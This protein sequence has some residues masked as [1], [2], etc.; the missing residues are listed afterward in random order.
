L[1]EILEEDSSDSE[2]EKGNYLVVSKEMVE[3]A[4]FK[5]YH[6]EDPNRQKLREMQCFPERNVC[7]QSLWYCLS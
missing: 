5:D 3:P 4:S 7:L 6:G 2:D 1:Q